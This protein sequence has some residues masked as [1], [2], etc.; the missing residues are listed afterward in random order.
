MSHLH[1]YA[2]LNLSCTNLQSFTSN[3][4]KIAEISIFRCTINFKVHFVSRHLCFQWIQHD[5]H[6]RSG[7]RA[8]DVQHPGAAP[9][10]AGGGVPVLF[11]MGQWICKCD[12]P[13]QVFYVSWCLLIN[14]IIKLHFVLLCLEATDEL[15]DKQL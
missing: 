10:C 12:E 9:C 4:Y 6:L 8:D 3:Y 1:G 15:S 7:R 11:H 13:E 5:L 14:N 2:S